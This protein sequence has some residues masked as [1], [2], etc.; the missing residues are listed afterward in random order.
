MEYR[1]DPARFYATFELLMLQ[2]E[3]GLGGWRSKTLLAPFHIRTKCQGLPGSSAPR[4]GHPVVIV[5]TTLKRSSW[6]SF[7]VS[8]KFEACHD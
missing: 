6:D 7:L 3:G 2:S 8:F 4:Q 5:A 1:G